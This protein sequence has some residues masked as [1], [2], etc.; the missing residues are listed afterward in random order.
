MTSRAA[1]SIPS[2]CRAVSPF[3][4]L[5]QAAVRA[6]ASRSIKRCF[7]LPQPSR[8]AYDGLLIGARRTRSRAPGPSQR[9]SFQDAPGGSARFWNRPF[10]PREAQE[11]LSSVSGRATPSASRAPPC[12]PVWAAKGLLALS[13][14]LPHGRSPASWRSRFAGLAFREEGLGS[15]HEGPADRGAEF[16]RRSRP[17]SSPGTRSPIP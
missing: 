6:S 12:E 16:D 10:Y 9:Q 2:S 5:S 1:S 13:A 7:N 4:T 14:N 15:S 17:T 8:A 11:R 3:D